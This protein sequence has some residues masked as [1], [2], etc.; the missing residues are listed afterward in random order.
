LAGHVYHGEY[1]A[2]Q[3]D[4]RHEPGRKIEA[5]RRRGSKY[6]KAVLVGKSR[7]DLRLRSALVQHLA[8]FLLHGASSRATQHIA[9]SQQLI[10]AAHAHKVIAD[11]Y[12]LLTIRRQ[13]ERRCEK[14]EGK[15]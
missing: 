12:D 5:R 11:L 2:C 8:D 15:K 10:T 3:S 13:A 6:A 1:S 14:H 4:K 7:K 9:D